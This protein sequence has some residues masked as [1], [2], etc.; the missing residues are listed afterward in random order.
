MKRREIIRSELGHSPTARLAEL[1]AHGLIK[2][3][4]GPPR[5][6]REQR[7][8]TRYRV[9]LTEERDRVKDRNRWMLRELMDDLGFD[10]VNTSNGQSLVKVSKKSGVFEG[11]RG[12]GQVIR[13]P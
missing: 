12:T 4:S 11:L 7:D 10:P 3:S 9:R 6:V 2:P 13:E 5:A 1:L 8:L